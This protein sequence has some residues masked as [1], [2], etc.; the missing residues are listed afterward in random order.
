MLASFSSNKSNRS[1]ISHLFLYLAIK[2]ESSCQ[3][4]GADFFIHYQNSFKDTLDML[5]GN[6]VKFKPPITEWIFAVPLLHFMM[7]KC[8]PYE[9]LRGLSWEFDD[10][11]R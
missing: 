5:I 1:V 3:I 8:K 2:D 11:T 10:F 6:A 7:K 4:I 9:P